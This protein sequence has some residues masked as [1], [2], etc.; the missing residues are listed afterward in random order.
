MLSVMFCVG[1]LTTLALTTVSFSACH[2]QGW[3]EENLVQVC[4]EILARHFKVCVSAPEFVQ[5]SPQF[6]REVFSSDALCVDEIDVFRAAIR[7]AES[8]LQKQAAQYTPLGVGL[9][10]LRSSLQC[11]PAL[12]NS[13]SNG[14]ST[15]VTVIG[16]EVEQS[17]GS[18]SRL[19]MGSSP[20]RSPQKARLGSLEGTSE[21][22][23]RGLRPSP[24]PPNR[25]IQP[26][27]IAN[28]LASLS[29]S[30]LSGSHGER[31]ACGIQALLNRCG[32]LKL[33]RF[34]LMDLNQ[35]FG[36]VRASG[37]LSEG[38]LIAIAQRIQGDISVDC[39]FSTVPRHLSRQEELA[40]RFSGHRSFAYSH[41]FDE[42]GVV[43]W[44]GNQV[45]CS[46]LEQ[47]RSGGHQ[48]P[49][50]HNADMPMGVPLEKGFL[51]P[52]GSNRLTVT[53]S[54]VHCMNHS[55]VVITSRVEQSAFWTRNELHSWV[56]FDF[57][58]STLFMPSLY[59]I[60]HG[61]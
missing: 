2:D 30:A 46:T 23:H 15:S 47:A 41:D 53:A 27:M 8:Q 32:L 36:E 39:G 48:S 44:L 52:H 1:H 28:A 3:D 22:H 45:Y 37:V 5:Q 7:W 20:N 40:G 51:N 43:F 4:H 34:P 35:L 49:L 56:E 42:N 19:R 33:I 14:S 11:S 38:E 18:P 17:H 12:N 55:P 58:D 6:V 61:K 10:R 50:R 13:S 25:L 59:T 54:S 24:H 60:R 9:K 16:S 21:D 57:G 31:G 26:S 29:S